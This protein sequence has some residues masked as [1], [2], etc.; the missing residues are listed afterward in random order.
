MERF[1]SNSK[2]PRVTIRDLVDREIDKLK[3]LKGNNAIRYVDISSIDN[4]S[5]KL[6]GFTEYTVEEAPSRAQ[7][8]IK[9]GDVLISTVRPKLQNIA[10]NQFDYNNLV[11]STGFCVLRCL[12]CLPEYMWG[13]VTSDEFTHSMCEQA[14]G[15]SYPAIRDNDVLQYVVPFPTMAEQTSYAT[16]VQQLDKSKFTVQKLLHIF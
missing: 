14:R 5:K 15:V 1:I 4:Q 11:A 3:N 12:R 7:Q 6:T 2:H 10:I 9:K 16:F 13:I 8:V